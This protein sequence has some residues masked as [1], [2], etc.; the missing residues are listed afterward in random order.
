MKEFVIFPF[1][2]KKVKKE[3]ILLEL[4]SKKSGFKHYNNSLLQL[5]QRFCI[6]NVNFELKLY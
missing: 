3:N 1:F 5:I 6:S 2:E 4:T